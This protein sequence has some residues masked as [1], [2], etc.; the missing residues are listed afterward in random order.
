MAGERKGKTYEAVVK[1]ILEDLRAARSVSGE[2]F[3]DEKPA[4]MLIKSDFLIGLTLDRPDHLILVTH[5]GASGNSH[6]KFWRNMGELVEAKTLLATVPAVWSIAFDSVI[7]DDLKTLQQVALDGQLIVGDAPYGPD[8]IRWVDENEDRL[9]KDADAKVNAIR[10]EQTRNGVFR[11]LLQDFR[12]DVQHLLTRGADRALVPLWQLARKRRVPASRLARNTSFK[13]GVAKLLVTRHPEKIL[14]S[15]SAGRAVPSDPVLEDLGWVSSSIAGT[16]VTDPDLLFVS[17]VSPT[18]LVLRQ[19]EALQSKKS[20]ADMLR[21]LRDAEA[22]LAIA[23]NLQLNWVQVQDPAWLYG[24]MLR[25]H[26]DPLAYAAAAGVGDAVYVRP[27]V[28]A[29]ALVELLKACGGRSQSFGL[30]RLVALLHGQSTNPAPYEQGARQLGIRTIK[31]RGANTVS[32]GYRDWLFGGDR[33]NFTIT[34]FELFRVASALTQAAKSHQSDD[35]NCAIGNLHQ[36]WVRNLF[37]AKF[38]SHRDLDVLDQIVL[39]AVEQAGIHVE[40]VSFFPSVWA[41]IAESRGIDLN[42][43]SGSTAVMQIGEALVVTKSAH[44]SHTNDKRKELCG[45]AFAMRYAWNSQTR[46][47]EARAGVRRLLLVV[48][49]SWSDDDLAGL[50]RAGWDGVFYPDEMPKLVATVKNR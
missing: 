16:R 45:R 33:Q 40:R 13:K 35:V 49:G 29:E 28:V 2:I 22:F 3:W 46:T 14:A 30:A 36:L 37:E 27:G 9:P 42:V 18:Q 24:E 23:R 5:S 39:E 21:P 11:K 38:A 48:D 32:Y 19:V 47:F 20:L 10:N 4:G 1:L 31:W 25:A 17:T 50:V 43:R 6:M 34:D 44:D 7:K 41:E 12:A 26:A 8:L 15:I